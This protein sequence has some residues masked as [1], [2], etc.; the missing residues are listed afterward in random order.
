MSKVLRCQE[1]IPG[2]PFVI[3]G[4]SEQEV[5]TQAAAHLKSAHNIPE[6]SPEFVAQARGAIRNE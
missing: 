3:Y 4:N 6:V 2:C 5:L 1:L